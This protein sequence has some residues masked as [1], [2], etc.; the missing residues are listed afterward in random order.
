MSVRHVDHA[1]VKL[2]EQAEH[3]ENVRGHGHLAA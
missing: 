1:V 3:L 2:G